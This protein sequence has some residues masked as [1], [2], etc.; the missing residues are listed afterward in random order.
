MGANIGSHNSV[1]V[2][3]ESVLEKFLF[4]VY[5]IKALAFS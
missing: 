5:D 2:L 1:S 3:V 4:S